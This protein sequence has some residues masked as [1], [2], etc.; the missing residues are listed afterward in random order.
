ME[1]QSK[2]GTDIDGKLISRKR[3]A[4]L[5]GNGHQGFR[6]NMAD[7]KNMYINAGNCLQLHSVSGQSSLI[8]TVQKH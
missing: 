4:G 3:K 1:N 7:D 6:D 2:D 5:S 8:S